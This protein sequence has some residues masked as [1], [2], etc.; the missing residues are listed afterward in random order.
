MREDKYAYIS[1]LLLDEVQKLTKNGHNWLKFLENVGKLYKYSFKDNLIINAQRENATMCADFD[2]WSKKLGYRIKQGTKGIPLLRNNNGRKYISYVYDIGDTVRT[3]K[4]RNVKFWTV[5]DEFKR[6]IAD[7]FRAHNGLSDKNVTLE[8]L[9]S[10][11][12]KTYL[13]ENIDKFIKEITLYKDGSLLEDYD[14]D[15][16]SVTL[17]D[18]AQE[19]IE[20]AVC[21]RCGINRD[22]DE[23][24]LH[25]IGDFNTVETI[26][27]LGELISQ[28]SET[29]LRE[30]E[31]EVRNCEKHLNKEENYYERENDSRNEAPVQRG[32]SE[33][34]A[35]GDDGEQHSLQAGR[36]DNDLSSA[37]GDRRGG[38]LQ[39]DILGQ[40]ET[41]LHQGEQA[42]IL[43]KTDDTGL[44]GTSGER[45]QA[46]ERDGEQP[47][48]GNEQSRG[49]DG[50]TQ[51]RKS[52]GMGG[53][54]EQ[55]QTESSRD[56]SE[57]IDIQLNNSEKA[58]DS[59]I[60]NSAFSNVVK[61]IDF[62]KYSDP[63]ENGRVERI[64]TA[65]VGEV[66]E[67]L[68]AHLKANKMLP[69]D[70]FILDMEL[71]KDEHI[72][73]DAE[74]ICHPY[75]GG[76]EGIYLD[77]VMESGDGN[78]AFA[79]GKTIDDNYA[80]FKRMGDIATECSLM[81]NSNGR[82]IDR[83]GITTEEYIKQ[84]KEQSKTTEKTEVEKFK[85]KTL[86][87][88]NP[89]SKKENSQTE[90]EEIEEQARR[91]ITE[92]IDSADLAVEIV[93]LAVYGSRSR[94]LEKRKFRY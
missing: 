64:G 58:E 41:H 30:I 37:V 40:E 80:A 53:S 93:D 66:F 2:T 62:E 76:S 51:D 94:G 34:V 32:T 27:Q 20:I 42:G 7:G 3:P 33:V 5:D 70:Y 71:G 50:A 26:S 35:G 83:N 61:T 81:L 28:C 59:S 22:F 38:G 9:I 21:S 17:K 43:S 39:S 86:K 82:T 65:T 44:V 55:P 84:H 73:E 23:Y 91:Y 74:F 63:D 36:G 85:E 48:E 4:S 67:Q 75:W 68:T 25:S 56:S 60:E 87:S 57:R 19:S 88:Y 69:D 31:K 13:D 15:N 54:E 6:A 16:L 90:I 14:R 77:I 49:D 24:A 18:I 46:G 89:I 78:K 79:T 11:R 10:E 52:D 12:V 29:V 1:E 8:G 92:F 72:P 47:D 45:G